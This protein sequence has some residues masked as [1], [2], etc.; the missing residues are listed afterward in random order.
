MATKDYYGILGISK[1]AT[2]KEIKSAFRKMAKQYHP[3]TNPDNPEAEK[4]FKE[5]NEAYAILSDPEKKKLYDQYGSAAFE[6]GFGQGGQGFGGFGNGG[7]QEFHFNGDG[8]GDIFGDLFGGMFGGRG[9]A[10]GYSGGFGQGQRRAAKGK[11]ITSEVT[12]TFEDAVYGCNKRIQF[13]D[14]NYKTQSLEIHIPA[15]IEEGKKIR[16]K[17]KGSPSPSG[18]PGDLFLI[19]HIAPKAGFERKGMDIYTTESIPFTTAVFG[20]EL[21][22]NTLYGKVVCAVKAGT[23]SGSKIRLRGKGVVSMKDST[24]KGDQYVTIQIKVPRDLDP[25]AA[26]KLREYEEIMKKKL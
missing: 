3:D 15:G 22:V 14:E 1:G 12:V 20:G 4:K 21:V 26:A 6:E 8:M 17:G 11:D 9:G 23:Q 16:L 7:Y 24:Q 13:R 10:G 19:V 25:E 18:Q 5:V 2:D